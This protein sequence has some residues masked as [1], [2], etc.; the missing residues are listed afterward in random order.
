MIEKFKNLFI[1]LLCF[2]VYVFR[3]KANKVRSGNNVII[4]QMGKLGDTVCITPMFAAIKEHYPLAKIY[5]LGKSLLNKELLSFHP[6][7]KEYIIFDGNFIKTVKILQSLKIDFGCTATPDFNS[8]ALMYCAGIPCIACPEVMGGYSPYETRPYKVLRNFVIKKPHHIGSYAPRE[9]LR[10]LEPIGIRSVYTKKYL[11]YSKDAEKRVLDYMMDNNVSPHQDFFVGISPSSGNPIKRWE[12]KKFSQVADY[13]YEK[14]HAVVF[15]IGSSADR[16]T[17]DEIIKNLNQKT[18]YINTCGK[19]S[20]DELKAFIYKLKLFISVDSG[21]IY[22][23]ESFNV[24]TIDIIGPMDENEQPPIGDLHKIVKVP[25]REKAQLH[26]M[27]ARVYNVKEAM[28]Q[29]QEI[30]VGMVTQQID[31]IMKK[32]N[33]E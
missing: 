5:I 10:L 2:F 21:P 12:E 13:L 24:S 25:H 22:I 20:I 23:A 9:Y 19:F 4:A 7:V 31:E 8:L 1:L 3:G 15:I 26:I 28:R 11:Y 27:N 30:T 18:R 6:D 32:I 16:D 14:Y 17:I 29:I 33:T